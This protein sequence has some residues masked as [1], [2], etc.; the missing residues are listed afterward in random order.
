MNYMFICDISV[1]NRNGKVRLDEILEPLRVDWR[2]LVVI[3][4]IDQVPGISQS[5]IIPFL[6]TDK[7]NVTKFL[8]SME[9]KGLLRR[10]VVKFDRRNK[11][12]HLTPKGAALAPKLREALDRWED[13]CFRGIDAGDRDAFRKVSAQVLHNL[14]KEHDREQ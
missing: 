3:L 14:M 11:A 10:A 6:Q 13:E 4:V 7:A 12:C 9:K 8:Q 1:F 5:R 2:E